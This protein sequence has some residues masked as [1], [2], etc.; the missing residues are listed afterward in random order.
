[1]GRY[2][3]DNKV[4]N[5]RKKSPAIKQINILNRGLD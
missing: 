3:N 5:M 1:M 4:E 2:G